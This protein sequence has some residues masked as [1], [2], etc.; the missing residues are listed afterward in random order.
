MA[1]EK[2]RAVVFDLDGVLVNSAECHRAAFDKVFRQFGILDFEYPSYAGHRTREVIEN[3]LRRAGIT[4]CDETVASAAR[5]KSRLARELLDAEKPLARGC[6]RVLAEVAQC[7][8]LALATCGSRQSA[9][10]FL[11][12]V[13][14][15]VIFQSVLT[16]DDVVNAKPHPEIYLRTVERLGLDPSECLVVEDSVAGIEAARAAGVKVVGLSGTCSEAELRRAGAARVIHRLTDLPSVL[17]DMEVQRSSRELPDSRL[18][19]AVIPAAGRASRLGFGRPKILYPVAGRPIL[20]WL[21]EFLSPNCASVVVVV[22]PEGK[23]EIARELGRRKVPRFEIVVQQ[24]PTGMGDA[25]ALALPSV[26]T[27]NVVIVWGDQVSLRRESVEQCLRL[28][29]GDLQPDATCP[30]VTRAHPYVHF[31]R[32]AQGQIIGVRLAHE[33]DLMPDRGESDTGLFCFRTQVLQ[34]LVA[35]L[36]RTSSVGASTREFNFLPVIPLAARQGLVLTPQFMR[37][38]ETVGVNTKEDA[39]AIERFLLGFSHVCNPS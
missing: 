13:G 38:E 16:G 26:R 25:V 27:P 29:Q 12:L 33:G 9:R 20:D 11:D 31:D 14:S 34:R 18:W 7:H 6:R 24:T 8:R 2:I 37:V 32:D 23:D 15:H 5:E 30:T 36:R 3:V 19:T 39:V 10:W 21:L 28:H 1:H 4:T 17:S 22:S 35:E